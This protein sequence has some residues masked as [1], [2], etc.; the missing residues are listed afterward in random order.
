M[1]EVLWIDDECKIN[2]DKLSPMGQE[3]IES[4]YE[5]GI[6]ITPM[7]TYKDGI[8]AIKNNPLEMV[9]CDS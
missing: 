8:D 9:C 7:L 1:I 2:S 6:K 4:A 5:E 3:F